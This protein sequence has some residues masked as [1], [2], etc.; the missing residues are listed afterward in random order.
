[1]AKKDKAEDSQDV[2]MSFGEHLE[3]LRK[4]ILHMGVAFLVLFLVLF[5]FFKG[6]ILDIVFFPSKPDFIT[7]RLF[8]LL[9]DATGVQSLGLNANPVQMYNVKMAGQFMLHIKTSAIGAL[10]LAFPY[11]ISQLWGFVRPALSKDVRRYCRRIVWKIVFWFFLGVSFSYFIIAPV[12]VSFLVNYEANVDI[13][14]IIDVAS[15]VGTVTG[16]CLAGGMVFQLP[17]LVRLLASIG[18][19]S[20]G[21]LRKNRKIAAVVLLVLSAMITPPDVMSQLLIFVP[22]YILYEYSISIAK[23]VEKMYGYE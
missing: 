7:N 22:F 13:D 8:A 3:E 21:W 20:S 15:Y 6:L 17:L 16:V 12:G 4:V 23:K 1:M 5:V 9:S 19:V 2:E 11:F 14:N 10:I 18:L